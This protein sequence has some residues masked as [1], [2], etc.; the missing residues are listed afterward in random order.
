MG[1]GFLHPP[2][3]LCFIRGIFD[4]V[5]SSFRSHVLAKCLTQIP[6]IHI[7]NILTKTSEII[8]ND[9]FWGQL[10]LSGVQYYF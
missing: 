7:Y 3:K 2:S 10:K 8:E 4:I 6:A 5:G 9:D 1:I